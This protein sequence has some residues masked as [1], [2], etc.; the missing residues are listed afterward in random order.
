MDA[1]KKTLSTQ[2]SNSHKTQPHTPRKILHFKTTRPLL[3]ANHHTLLSRNKQK[4][5]IYPPTHNNTAH[6][7]IHTRMQSIRYIAIYTE[8]IQIKKTKTHLYENTG[9]HLITIPTTRLEW[10]WKQYNKN[11]YNT[12]GLVPQP[13]S[14]EKKIIW[15]YQRYKHKPS[16]KNPFKTTQHTLPT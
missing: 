16:M 11:K 8:T 12:H 3:T 2:L 15:L 4:P 5:E 7:H 10:L 1:T 9:R 6:T 14:F 13:Q